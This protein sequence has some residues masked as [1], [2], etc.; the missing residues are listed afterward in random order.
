MERHK[1]HRKRHT[2]PGPAGLVRTNSSYDNDS[3]NDNNQI[4]KSN[5]EENLTR[6]S[7]GNDDVKVLNWT[8]PQSSLVSKSSTILRNSAVVSTT[9]NLN[10][11]IH[12]PAWKAM[13]ICLDRYIPPTSHHS[14]R[15]YLP[16]NFALLSDILASSHTKTTKDCFVV[17]MITSVQ[18]N[19]HCDWTCEL[20]DDEE[21]ENGSISSSAIGWLEESFIRRVKPEVIARPGVVLL[22]QN[23]VTTAF[24]QS[25]E[26]EEDDEVISIPEQQQQQQEK[27]EQM[28]L[29]GDKTVIHMWL[30]EES[31]NVRTNEQFLKCQQLQLQR[32]VSNS[33]K[34]MAVNAT[35]SYIIEEDEEE[36]HEISS[37]PLVASTQPNPHPSTHVPIVTNVVLDNVIPPQPTTNQPSTQENSIPNTN[38]NLWSTNDFSLSLCSSTNDSTSSIPPHV[39]NT[40]LQTTRITELPKNNNSNATPTI[41]PQQQ[42]QQQ[43]QQ[44]CITTHSNSN[45]T[46]IFEDAQK[47]N[48]EDDLA[49][50][51]ATEFLD[52]LSD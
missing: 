20:V 49:L 27:V 8:Q 25:Q 9:T 34:E 32:N 46:F 28:I 39:D 45:N 19:M 48:E 35:N 50:F 17:A 11:V 10:S 18:C 37:S 43:P 42:Y 38:N 41:H 16:T 40:E 31:S 6:A 1:R 5:E 30:P 44:E 24:L 3:R 15:Q 52:D 51:H 14:I 7:K 13:C 47:S 21:D 12:Q 29:I 2:L 22:L 33:P 23:V 26:E 36:D 4:E